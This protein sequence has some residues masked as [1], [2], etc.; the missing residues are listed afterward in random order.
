MIEIILF[1]LFSAC[2]ARTPTCGSLTDY[3]H[4]STG[5]LPGWVLD[6][7]AFP[8]GAF[9]ASFIISGSSNNTE[10]LPDLFDFYLANNTF[11]QSIPLTN[12]PQYPCPNAPYA[13]ATNVTCASNPLTTYTTA[14]ANTGIVLIV[15]CKNRQAGCNIWVNATLF[16][17]GPECS[18]GC[19]SYYVGNGICNPQCVT[20]TCG[21]DN[22][23]CSYTQCAPGCAISQYNDGTCNAVCNNAPCNYDGTDCIL[24][25]ATGCSANLIG[26]GQCNNACNTAACG[27]DQGDCQVSSTTMSVPHPSPAVNKAFARRVFE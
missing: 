1:F 27:Y 3:I 10:G 14:E 6:V 21:Y 8:G 7:F 23:D 13:C 25:C 26:N 20:A 18:P 11:Y 17:V 15:A 12:P 24:P 4:N 22:G 19:I 5:S 16:G 9:T 2:I